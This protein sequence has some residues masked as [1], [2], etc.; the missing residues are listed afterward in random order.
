MT[1]Q[2]RGIFKKVGS[3]GYGPKPVNPVYE[4]TSPAGQRYKVERH[5]WIAPT[6]YWGWTAIPLMPTGTARI[7]MALEKTLFEDTLE[8]LAV[9]MGHEVEGW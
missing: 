9:K 2:L 1:K 4:A 7:D 8:R 6:T 5:Q 3:D